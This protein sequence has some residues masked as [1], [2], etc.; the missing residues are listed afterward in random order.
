M[1]PSK[2]SL[3]L[4][5]DAREVEWLGVDFTVDGKKIQ[6]AEGRCI[7]VRRRED[8]FAGVEACARVVVV[9]GD[10]VGASGNCDGKREAC[11]VGARA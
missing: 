10:S 4:E 8:G 9:L 3:A 7:H 6:L 11:G 5:D 1:P 2:L